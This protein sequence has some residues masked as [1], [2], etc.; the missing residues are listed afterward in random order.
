MSRLVQSELSGKMVPIKSEEWLHEC[1]VSFLL[2]LPEAMRDAL[3]EGVAG[4]A[5]R[6]ALGIRGARGDEAAA[7]LRADIDRLSAIRSGMR[8]DRC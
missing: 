2:G 7:I 5:G 4:S 1:E 3:I 8:Q 6:E